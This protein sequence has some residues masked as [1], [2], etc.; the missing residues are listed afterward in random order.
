[1]DFLELAKMRYSCRSYQSKMVEE[2]KILK[3]LEACALAPSACNLQP[4]HF[5]VL[6]EE[7]I[8]QE[9]AKAYPSKWFKEAP[10]VI[11]ACGDHSQCWKRGDGKSSCDIDTAIAVD[12][13]T[14]AAADLGLGTCW[15]CA[16][17]AELCRKALNLPDHIEPIALI[18][19]GYP[20]DGMNLERHYSRKSLDEM[21]HW[22]SFKG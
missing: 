8:K 15:V 18:P 5:I 16:F 11:V 14:L 20:S 6:R 2:E 4:C 22:D 13:L 7:G 10:V 12:H 1:M 21:V 17:D 19:L 3:V 9:V